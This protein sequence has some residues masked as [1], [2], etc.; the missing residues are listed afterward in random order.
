VRLVDDLLDISR[1]TRGK[2]ELRKYRVDLGTAIAQA[3]EIASPLFEQR[4]H[5]VSIAVPRGLVYVDGDE[6]RLAQV[7]QNL[8]TN[9]A[10]YTPSGGSITVRMTLADEHAVVDIEDNGVGIAA[11]MLAQIFE[12]F[13][14]GSQKLDRSEGG[15]G[16]GLTLVRSLAELHGGCV[17]AHSAG[18]GQGSR[19]TVRLPLSLGMLRDASR[20]PKGMVPLRTS[21]RRVLLVDDNR[22][23]AE[24]LAELL[25]AAGHEVMVAFDGP[26]ALGVL[27][28]FTP[29]VA[30]LDIGLPVMDGYDLARKL[31]DAL[32][33]APRFVAITG[34]GSE[35]DHKRSEEAGFEAHLVKP[36][37]AEQL[38]AA[39][40]H[41]LS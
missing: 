34:Y 5:H 36:V 33:S 39:V 1:I 38:L 12:P 28:G 8:L 10:K 3:V 11:D 24:M 25:R 20:T 4:S 21:K 17:D 37:Q 41:T 7:F 18:P 13:M 9:A 22:D 6:F 40:D 32:P 29:D 31:R 26:S 23:A 30:L 15:L 27:P 14:Q 2:L 16:I 19:F 35:H